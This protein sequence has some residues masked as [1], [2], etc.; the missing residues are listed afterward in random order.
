MDNRC[1]PGTIRL[2]EP[3]IGTALPSSQSFQHLLGKYLAAVGLTGLPAQCTRRSRRSGLWRQQP[4]SARSTSVRSRASIPAA[5]S[6]CMSG[7]ATG[8][9]AVHDSSRLSKAPSGTPRTILPSFPIPGPT[10]RPC[11]RISPFYAA[12]WETD[13]RWSAAQ[14]TLVRDAYDGGSGDEISNGLTNLYN[15]MSP[16]GIVLV[17]STSISSL[18]NRP[19][20][21]HHQHADHP[22]G[23]RRKPGDHLAWWRRPDRPPTQRRASGQFRRVCLE[24]GTTSGATPFRLLMGRRLAGAYSQNWSGSGRRQ[25]D[26]SCAVLPGAYGLHPVTSDPQAATGRGLRPT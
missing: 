12:N 5:T 1:R 16:Y 2:I 23:A 6:A 10:T 20:R 21:S 15:S 17:G 19:Q 9:G 8:M 22:T 4:T 25:S 11:R 3:G 18:T 13:G 14:Q 26:T 24:P 7:P